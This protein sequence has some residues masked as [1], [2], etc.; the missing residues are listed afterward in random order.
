MAISHICS[1][2]GFDLARIRPEP[3]AHYGLRIVTCP[4]CDQVFVRRRHP[5]DEGIRRFRQMI[6]SVVALVGNGLAIGILL[7]ATVE[8]WSAVLDEIRNQFLMEERQLDL[9]LLSVLPVWALF[10]LMSGIWISAPLAHWKRSRIWLMWMGLLL[11]AA[12]LP[13]FSGHLERLYAI[14]TGD[15]TWD[16]WRA[17]AWPW[18]R[19]GGILV[20][21]CIIPF[22]LPIGDRIRGA[23]Q[24]HR[25]ARWCRRRRKLRAWRFAE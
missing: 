21:A 1:E 8:G 12:M 2:C 20:I 17:P 19:L 13:W 18:K 22:G 10:A 23:Y 24:R 14:A 16:W 3:E 15:A 9:V 5:V 25:H 11:L 7:Y 6:R 4:R